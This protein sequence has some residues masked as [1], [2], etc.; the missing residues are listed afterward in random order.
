M[1][2]RMTVLISLR[3]NWR[4]ALILCSF[5][6]SHCHTFD[7]S[8]V[9]LLSLRMPGAGGFYKK[10][11]KRAPANPR[12]TTGSSIPAPELPLG[13]LEEELVLLPPL[14]P[15]VVEVEV[16]VE[17]EVAMAEG[18]PVETVPLPAMPLEPA[19]DAVPAA[20]PTTAIRVV[21]GVPAGTVATEGWVVTAK[22][23]VV[24]AE[25]W[26]VMGRAVHWIS[27]GMLQFAR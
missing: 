18:E 7:S 19:L 27:V 1:P 17:L 12:P 6:F 15:P 16:E 20:V 13:L 14:E 9:G 8:V 2:N 5:G 3:T 10:A 4:N 26:V 24:T 11:A 25:G 21:L 23:W 22:G